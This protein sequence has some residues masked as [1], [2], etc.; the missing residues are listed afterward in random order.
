MTLARSILEDGFALRLA[1]VVALAVATAGCATARVE[2]AFPAPSAPPWPLAS[3]ECR[4]GQQVLDRALLQAHGNVVLSPHAIVR[5]LFVLGTRGDERQRQQILDFFGFRDGWQE[6]SNLL[7]GTYADVT[8]GADAPDLD[9]LRAGRLRYESIVEPLAEEPA[10]SEP[11]NAGP[12]H[13]EF[14]RRELARARV[15]RTHHGLISLFDAQVA[16]VPMLGEPLFR[17]TTLPFAGRPAVSGVAMRLGA[18]YGVSPA[19]SSAFWPA[20]S[21]GPDTVPARLEGGVVVTFSLPS[22]EGRVALEQLPVLPC[23][24]GGL[25]PK[26]AAVALDFRAPTFCARSDNALS[27]LAP[28]LHAALGVDVALR[29]RLAFDERGTLNLPPRPLRSPGFLQDMGTGHPAHELHLERPFFVTVH[30]RSS[31]VIL[32]VAHVRTPSDVSAC[33]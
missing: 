12:I 6:L 3:L 2:P 25:P 9:A 30:D 17:R 33:E 18:S 20:Q 21:D 31:G 19:F 27:D 14:N 10:E 16:G 15:A 23:G 8:W 22:G 4:V 28:E 5:A 11:W 1:G 29:A 26:S 7:A 32:Y 13:S 24:G